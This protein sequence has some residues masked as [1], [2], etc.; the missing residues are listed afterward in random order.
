MTFWFKI[1][2]YVE[3][4]VPARQLYIHQQDPGQ[5]STWPQQEAPRFPVDCQAV[6]LLHL[7]GSSESFQS[8]SH[9]DQS[10][11]NLQ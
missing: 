1:Q 7:S 6:E 3:G 2:G 8:V 4:M 10:K 5:G 9:S 11:S